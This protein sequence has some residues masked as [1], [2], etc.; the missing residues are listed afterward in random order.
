MTKYFQMK[1]K[2]NFLFY[3]IRKRLN[4]FKMI[5]NNDGIND[6]FNS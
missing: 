6:D 1:N 5:V 4:A 2:S 3:F